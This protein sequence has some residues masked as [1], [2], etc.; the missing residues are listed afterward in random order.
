MKKMILTLSTL[1][2]MNTLANQLPQLSGKLT[3]PKPKS[4]TIRQKSVM[5][6][7]AIFKG[8]QEG[9][10]GG[11]IQRN[12]QVMTF[13]TAKVYTESLAYSNEQIINELLEDISLIKS[14]PQSLTGK[15]LA[16]MKPS[17]RRT[18]VNLT[19]LDPSTKSR[20]MAEYQ[21]ITGF[22]AKKLTLF[23]LTDSTTKTTFIL[24]E[25]YQ[26]SRNE[27]KAILFH[28][29]IWILKP[30]SSYNQII[31]VEMTFQRYLENPN[32]MK[33]IY[34]LIE[35]LGSRGDLL[36]FSLASDLESKELDFALIN[37]ETQISVLEI[38]GEKFITCKFKCTNYAVDHLRNLKRQHPDSLFI[39]NMFKL[40][41]EEKLKMSLFLHKIDLIGEIYPIIGLSIDEV[42]SFTDYIN[43]TS[44]IDSY[45]YFKV[46]DGQAKISV[47]M[48]LKPD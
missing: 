14:M 5:S 22:K 27:Q 39:K 31:S 28:E 10:G 40:F 47:N 7:P 34:Q 4:Q 20:L 18:Y 36:K 42:F 24:P 45:F 8:G 9:N 15:L 37:D 44:D 6:S 29:G 17:N 2:S 32:N 11:G 13:Y 46:D 12:G 38:F 21:R 23:A 16:A 35:N 48:W 19:N 3:I 43:I 25:F 26:L 41:S 1:I 30:D 33:N